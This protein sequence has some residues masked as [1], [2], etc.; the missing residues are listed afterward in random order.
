MHKLHLI[1]KTS[2]SP[3]PDFM[4]MV[5]SPRNVTLVIN[6]ADGEL[7]HTEKEKEGER[8]AKT[9]LYPLQQTNPNPLHMIQKYFTV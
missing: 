6:Y 9:I 5:Q 8:K 4:R 3:G 7:T 1:I 2:K